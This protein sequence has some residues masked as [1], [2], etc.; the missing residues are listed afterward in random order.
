V[1]SF[2]DGL[3][4]ITSVVREARAAGRRPDAREAAKDAVRHSGSSDYGFVL[5]EFA[6]QYAH[7]LTRRSVLLVIGDARSNYGDPATGAFAEIRQRAGQVYWLNPEPR[8]YWND[9]DSVIGRYA[10]MCAQ[11]R[12]CRTL[13]QIA[14]FV[15][16]LTM[17]DGG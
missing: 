16:S 11:V 4:E 2:I 13:R 15:E 3:A 8:R 10:P 12:E 6:R 1:F 7:Q 9:G 14:D 17:S 5:R